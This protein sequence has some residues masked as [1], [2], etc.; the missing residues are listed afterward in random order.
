MRKP[1]LR[2]LLRSRVL[3]HKVTPAMH[4]HRR[5]KHAKTRMNSRI[6]IGGGRSIVV[7]REVTGDGPTQAHSDTRLTLDHRTE[8]QHTIQDAGTTAHAR[9]MLEMKH[10]GDDATAHA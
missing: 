9:K 7:A 5:R 2:E 1:Q 3:E 8:R 6:A 10:D 4:N